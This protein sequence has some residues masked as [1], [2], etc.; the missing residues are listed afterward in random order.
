MNSD[1]I[2]QVFITDNEAI[3]NAWSFSQLYHAN[4]LEDY[5]NG[6]KGKFE[7]KPIVVKPSWELE[8]GN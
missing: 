5:G 6:S 3:V 1:P 8:D 4:L 7:C 2:T